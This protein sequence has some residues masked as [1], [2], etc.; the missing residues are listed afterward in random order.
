M[1]HANATIKWMRLESNEAWPPIDK[2]AG[3][4]RFSNDTNDWPDKC[5]TMIAKCLST[6]DS[7]WTWTA[8]VWFLA[9]TAPVHFFFPGNCFEFV[10]IWDTVGEGVIFENL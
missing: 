8:D 3:I 10:E 7:G 6:Q 9:D 5:W 4:V 2:Y 1:R